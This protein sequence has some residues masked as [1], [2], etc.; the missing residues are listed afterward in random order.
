MA[1]HPLWQE[2]TL[3]LLIVATDIYF[4]QPLNK[5]RQVIKMT[6]AEFYPACGTWFSKGSLK[7]S[8]EK[9][10]TVIKPWGYGAGSWRKTPKS[11]GWFVIRPAICL[12]SRLTKPSQEHFYELKRNKDGIQA[13]N[14][15]VLPFKAIAEANAWQQFFNCIPTDA[16]SLV[17]RFKTRHWHLL[18]LLNRVG[19]PAFDLADCPILLFLVS[20]NWVLGRRTSWIQRTSRRLCKIKRRRAAAWLGFP[21]REA[22]I[23]IF[24]KV[25]T[26]SISIEFCFYLR[27]CINDPNT[28]KLLAH[29]PRINSGT[30]RLLGQDLVSYITPELLWQTGL[31]THNDRKPRTAYLLI[32][33][34]RIIKLL[35]PDLDKK[36]RFRSTFQLRSAHDE[37]V[38][39]LNYAGYN[40]F[41]SRYLH[42]DF[43][44]PPDLWYP[45]GNI[46]TV[47]PIT[48]PKD[49]VLFGQEQCN[50]VASFSHRVSR[51]ECFIFRVRTKFETAT[52]ALQKHR[53]RW[54]IMELKSQSNVEVSPQTNELVREWLAYSQGGRSTFMPQDFYDDD[55]PF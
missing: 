41:E 13:T 16:L 14:Q 51:G 18:Q 15:L 32:D 38:D 27:N 35:R 48:N 44:Q 42:L 54:R 23:N 43:P 26:E 28:A 25:P 33:V 52:L 31:D 2:I 4:F 9:K 47:S 30:I 40:L 24:R 34:I 11:K 5:E 20:S 19:S 50:C 45:D 37:W 46:L 55:I 39:K 49:L 53:S 10:V 8:S 1:M 22:T 21:D 7:I 12:D 6:Q 36:T 3:Y 29:A 17:R